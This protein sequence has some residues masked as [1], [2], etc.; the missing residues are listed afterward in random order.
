MRLPRLPASCDT[1]AATQGS[2]ASYLHRC[3]S[4]PEILSPRPGPRRCA[5][6]HR[7]SVRPWG[8]AGWQHQ[9]GG[10]KWGLINYSTWGEN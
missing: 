6:L 10:S 1:Q 8:E 4:G 7:G 2:P 3:W 5:R 9:P